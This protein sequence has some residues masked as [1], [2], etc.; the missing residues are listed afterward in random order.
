MAH[1]NDRLLLA[2]K[3]QRLSNAHPVPKAVQTCQS[4]ISETEI[5]NLA[6]VWKENPDGT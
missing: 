1:R 5:A 3:G 6:P 2:H 4:R